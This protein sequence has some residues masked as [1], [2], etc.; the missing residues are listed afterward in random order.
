[1]QLRDKDLV[2]SSGA[3]RYLYFPTTPLPRVPQCMEAL[4]ST[5]PDPGKISLMELPIEPMDHYVWGAQL[6][7]KAQ[8]DQTLQIGCGEVKRQHSQDSQWDRTPLCSQL[9][10]LVSTHM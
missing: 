6:K 3:V 1:M 8:I 7:V 10:C 5:Q 9:K 2:G 4:C